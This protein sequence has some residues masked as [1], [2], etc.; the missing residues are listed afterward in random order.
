VL[1]F[2]WT[3]SR[4]ALVALGAAAL[5][6]VAEDRASAFPHVL[7]PNETL[8]EV[9]SRAYGRV[10]LEQVLVAAN[11][12]DLGGP[13][14]VVPGT[15]IEVPVVGYHRVSAGD[16]W[17]AL[18]AR[19]LGDKRRSEVLA[20]VN[21]A[22]IWVP[23]SPGRELVI[24]YNLRY[25][26]KS[27]DSTMTIAYRFL[28]KRDDAWVIDRYNDLD[29]K[30]VDRG[31]VL[32]VP[33]TDLPLSDAGREEA[34]ELSGLVRGAKAGLTHDAQE[35]VDGELPEL[36]ARLRDGRWLEAVAKGNELLGYGDLADPQLAAIH[37]V[38]LEAYVALDAGPLATTACAE[39][40]RADP[41]AEL[42]PVWISPKLLK[43]CADAAASRR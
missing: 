1:C 38:L 8:A 13:G 7:M 17:E 20:R 34:A 11:G 24:P 5:V 9:A 35:V 15:R 19:Y 30:P 16:T 31:D 6:A 23:P 39:W 43:A 41:D 3:R 12:L 32:L 10:E 28:G 33:L 29:G 22:L 18:A 4:A 36:S 21:D 2:T 26:V 27:G 14:A 25:V 42:D 40:R 37:R